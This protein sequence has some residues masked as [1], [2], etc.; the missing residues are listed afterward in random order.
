MVVN[1]GH[2]D[3]GQAPRLPTN[4]PKAVEDLIKE[5]SVG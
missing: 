4:L 3:L 2:P 5:K 1:H